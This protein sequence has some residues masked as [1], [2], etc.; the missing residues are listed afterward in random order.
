MIAPSGRQDGKASQ[1]APVTDASDRLSADCHRIEEERRQ[2]ESGVVHGVRDIIPLLVRDGGC[3]E[4]VPV[5]EEIQEA[6]N[7]PG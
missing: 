5:V 3:D 2:G 7:I 6:I 4:S 1:P